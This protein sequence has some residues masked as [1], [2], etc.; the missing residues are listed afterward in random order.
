M[1]RKR[2]TFKEKNMGS[3]NRLKK[4]VLSKENLQNL[5]DKHQIIFLKKKFNVATSTFYRLCKEW[6][7]TTPR[8]KS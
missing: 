8:M 7:I 4:E 6:N 5:V 3:F 1:Q 2:R